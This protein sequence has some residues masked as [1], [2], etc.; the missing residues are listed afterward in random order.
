[1]GLS[2]SV[3]SIHNLLSLLGC[4][5]LKE[6]SE[7]GQKLTTTYVHNNF[8]IDFKSSV[9]TVEAAGPMLQHFTAALMFPLSHSKPDNLCYSDYLW[10]RSQLNSAARPEMI[11]PKI[12]WYR[13]AEIHA[14]TNDLDAQNMTVHDQFRSWK[15]LSDLCHHGPEEFRVFC[16]EIG[17]PEPIE[18]ISTKKMQ[19]IPLWATK[20][21]N[22]FVGGNIEA[23]YHVLSQVGVEDPQGD[24]DENVV[25]V[26]T[27]VILFH[28]DLGSGEKIESGLE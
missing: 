26:A 20:D 12:P 24:D 14:H 10:Q 11:S 18:K 8:D 15:F 3:R 4:H 21:N 22:S 6:A 25:K 7:L 2:V 17:E 23:I 27:Y 5:A 9:P 1:M 13:L 19:I 28:G 16:S